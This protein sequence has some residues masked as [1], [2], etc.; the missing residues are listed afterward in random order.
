M[1]GL[2][3]AGGRPLETLA[4]PPVCEPAAPC[5]RH[6]DVPRG[7]PDCP[8]TSKGPESPPR[9]VA[10]GRRL[11]RRSRKTA[12][13]SSSA[14]RERTFAKEGPHSAATGK[15]GYKAS[16]APTRASPGRIGRGTGPKGPTGPSGCRPADTGSP[17]TGF[18][19]RC[20]RG[21]GTRH[22]YPGSAALSARLTQER[23]SGNRAPAG[24]HRRRGQ[25]PGGLREV[26]LRAPRPGPFGS[27][28]GKPL[29]IPARRPGAPACPGGIQAGMK[30]R[31]RP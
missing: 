29:E 9:H 19:P 18:S 15:A 7:K 26:D 8:G 1:W 14:F 24:A 2:P 5:G 16:R 25:G 30:R 11:P 10:I 21:G 20:P 6:A 13:H 28:G 31:R 17:R 4:F 3:W 12:G 27:D 23:G 22:P